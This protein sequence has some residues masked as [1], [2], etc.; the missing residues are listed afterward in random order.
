MAKTGRNDLCPCGSGRKYKKCCE[1][2]ERNGGTRSRVMLFAV[3]GAVL[4]A[5]LAG[6]ASFTGEAVPDQTRVWSP[7]HGHYHDANGVVPR[8]FEP[9]GSVRS[10]R[11]VRSPTISSARSSRR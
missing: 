6:I 10:V 8:S 7:E 9:F 1:A 11:A 5:L 4:V 3:G 2:A